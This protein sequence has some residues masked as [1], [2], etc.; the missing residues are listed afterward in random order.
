MMRRLSLKR[1]VEGVDKN[2]VVFKTLKET[3]TEALP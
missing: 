3:W 2:E 1:E